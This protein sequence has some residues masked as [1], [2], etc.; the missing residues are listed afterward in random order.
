GAIGGPA[1]GTVTVDQATGTFTYNPDDAYALTGGTDTFTYT[2]S[3]AAAR[4]TFFGIPL[5][6]SATSATG[7][8]TVTLNRVP[9]APVINNDDRTTVE[10]SPITI[11]V[12]GN[13]T[14]ANGEALTVS[15][16][17]QGTHGTT[18]FT[19]SGVTYTPNANF[20][21]ADSFTYTATDG[22][23]TGT[24]TVTV[25]V[26]AIDDAPVAVGDSVTVAEDSGP[27]VIAVLANDTDI[28]AG[29]KT[30]T[31]VTQ[32]AHGTVTF[33]GTT[34]SYTPTANY[35]GTDTFSYT[36][37]GGATAAVAVTV[38]AVDD[39]PVAVGDSATVAEDSGPTV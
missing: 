10:D 34:V 3:D 18:T 26:T 17:S 20:V 24:A 23:L 19:A 36:L 22:S 6:R 1:H 21:G 29:P 39:A 28:D 13:D 30:I 15:G 37:N 33:T 14:D 7:T 16:V 25:T 31:A 2:V 8:V 4:R 38:T 27:T 9:V 11:A 5:S 32:P 35:T 12:L